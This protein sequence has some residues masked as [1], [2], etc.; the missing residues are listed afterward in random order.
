MMCQRTL[1]ALFLSLLLSQLLA[2]ARTDIPAC[3]RDIR[4]WEDARTIPGDSLYAYLHESSYLVRREA[5]LALGRIGRPEAVPHLAEVLRDDRRPEVRAD[6]AFAL[7]LIPTS[8]S[9]VALLAGVE[10]ELSLMAG[11][12]R[13]GSP[14]VLG[15]VL[16]ALGRVDQPG[17]AGEVVRG[18][19]H[20]HPL[21]REQALESLAL[22][23]DST[24][25]DEI[26]RASHDPVESVVWRAAYALGKFQDERAVKREI[27]LLGHS[28]GLVRAFAARGL[29]EIGPPLAL[30]GQDALAERLHESEWT[31]RVNAARSLGKLGA[32]SQSTALLSVLDDEIFHARA[33]ALEALQ[34]LAPVPQPAAIVDACR[35]SCSV[36]RLAAYAAVA[37]N[38]QETAAPTLREGLEDSSGVVRSECLELLGQHPDAD[39]FRTLAAALSQHIDE[40]IRA[41]AVEGL[42]SLGGEKAIALLLASLKDGDWV[43]ATTAAMNLGKLN[44]RSAID[45]LLNCYEFWDRRDNV[46]VCEATLMSMGE[47]RAKRA[48]E[49]LNRVLNESSDRRL[50]VAARTA[51]VKILPERQAAGLPKVEDIEMDVRPIRRSSKQ[52]PLVAESD[53]RELILHTQRGTIVIDL[54]YE[55]APQSCESFA[56]LAEAGF[57]N[58]LDFHRVVPNFVIQ[59]GD[60]LGSGWGDAGYLLRSEWSPARYDR[61]TVGIATNGKDTGSCQLFITHSPEPRLNARYT[62]IGRVAEGMDVVDAIQI[63][64]SFTAE[65]MWTTPR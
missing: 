23:A 59:G 61:G 5:A 22:L 49:V 62:I 48:S 25:V 6:A 58:G 9:A 18:L 15:E 36:V 21:V 50:R 11:S 52:P 45:S 12:G 40:E 39:A 19:S 2:C 60:P 64:D 10:K 35:D 17:T 54:L 47:L 20:P 56:R 13:R 57:F 27:E 37:A 38:L 3:T 44:V 30:V 28:S 8:A 41:H 65:A 42:A 51:L 33:A 14:E 46:G 53:A 31:V 4:R 7:G 63:E 34:Q 24:T 16:L 55:I 29:G 32:R 26:L 43:V 1:S